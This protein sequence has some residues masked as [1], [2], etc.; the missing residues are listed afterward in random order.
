MMQLEAAH[1]HHAKVNH[2]VLAAVA[3]GLRQL[4]A[5]RDEHAEDLVLRGWP[6]RCRWARPTRFAGC[7]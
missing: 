5:R 4:L 7:G 3:G 1:A 6:C 2:V